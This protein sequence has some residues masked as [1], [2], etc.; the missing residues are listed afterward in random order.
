MASGYDQPKTSPQQ[1]A[2]RPLEGIRLGQDHVLADSSAEEMWRA[3]R[4]GPAQLAATMQQAWIKGS[5]GAGPFMAQPSFSAVQRFVPRLGGPEVTD[6]FS[7][8]RF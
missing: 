3:T 7:K 1:V 5:H 8:R 2:E 4:S 6:R